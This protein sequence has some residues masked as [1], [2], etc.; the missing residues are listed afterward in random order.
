MYQAAKKFRID[1]DIVM[2]GFLTDYRIGNSHYQ[3][4]G[5]D[6][7]FGF[8]GYCFPKDLNAFINWLK[9]IGM[10]EEAHLFE[11]IWRLNLKYRKNKDWEHLESVS[12]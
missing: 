11:L 9:S 1:W 2:K 8:G 7:D 10:N 12:S 6:G 3:V 5:F 4:P